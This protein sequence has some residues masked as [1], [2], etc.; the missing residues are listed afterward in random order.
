MSPLVSPS[1]D[2]GSALAPDARQGR[3][4]E[5]AVLFADL[6]GFTR[7]A[8]YKLPYDVVF[9]LNRYFATVGTAIT[10]AFGADGEPIV[11]ANVGTDCRPT[12]FALMP[13]T[14]NVYCSVASRPMC[15]R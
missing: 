3:E 10:G 4:R 11:V 14:V 15:R 6:R 2:P 9:V 13:A 7:M 12:P 1:I 8:E 5:V